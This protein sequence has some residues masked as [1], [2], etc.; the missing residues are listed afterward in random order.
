M[1]KRNYKYNATVDLSNIPKTKNN[2]FYK[3]NDAIG[4][5]V[6]FTFDNDNLVG[7][8]EIVDYKIPEG[9]VH[10]HI[11]LKYNDNI[12]K[13]I[14]SQGLKN[15][16]FSN[17]LDEYYI[18]WEYNIGDRLVDDKRDITIIDRKRIK[19][20]N[21]IY[22]KYYK[23]KCNVCGFNSGEYYLDGTYYNEW[24][25][26]QN[27]LKRKDSKRIN[28]PCCGNRIVVPGINDIPTTTSW[29][30]EYFQGGYEEAKKYTYGSKKEIFPICPNCKTI[31]D[32]PTSIYEIYVLNG[33][34]CVCNDKLSYPN[35]FAYYTFRQLKKQ[36]DNYIREYS[37]K[38]SGYYS[39]DNYI[40]KDKKKIIFEMDG[41]IGHGKYKYKSKERDTEG[42]KRDRIKDDLAKEHNIKVERIDCFY[43]EFYYI[44]RNFEKCLR[45]Y[46]DLSDID[47]DLI[48]AQCRQGNIY[49]EICEYYCNNTNIKQVDIAK[50]FNV[51]RKIVMSALKAGKKF[52]WCEYYTNK[53]LH[54]INKEKIYK[55]WIK[56]PCLSTTKI[57]KDLNLSSTTVNKILKE[58]T[59]ENKIYYNPQDNIK[60][61]NKKNYLKKKV[62]VYNLSYELLKIYDSG[63]D[64]SLNSIKDFGM[65]FNER[66]INMACNGNLKTYKGYIFSKEPL[67]KNFI[68]EDNKHN[69]IVYVYDLNINF[70]KCYKSVKEAAKESIYDF[71]IQFIASNISSVCTGRYKQHKGFIFSH[72]KLH[73]D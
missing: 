17:I 61:N 31:I 44:K 5:I 45:K 12:L 54:N 70:L 49:K 43:S 52:G 21:G 16:T 19:D 48:E 42:L 14:L 67:N 50:Y 11:Y 30:V 7:E 41:G 20:K 55:Y 66:C 2:K 36:Y 33:V 65:L 18:E 46:F 9:L 47:W 58:L 26:V 22:N 57:G 63:V 53:E 15:A 3:W 51:G 27:E 73:N 62:Y 59:K 29:M 6:P 71:N 8:F 69:K 10:P 4:C 34:S 23:I 24:W 68:L 38:W 13:P 64:C 72:V 39:Y 28:C 35:K 25:V 37:P 60:E 32:K 1:A 40:E 56:N